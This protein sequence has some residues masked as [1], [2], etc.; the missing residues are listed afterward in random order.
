MNGA[1]TGNAAIPTRVGGSRAPFSAY[2][3][4]F[5]VGAIGSAIATQLVAYRLADNPSLGF[6]LV[7]FPLAGALYAPWAWVSWAW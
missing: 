1:R 3:G 5:A 7:R 4:A 2:L 6:P